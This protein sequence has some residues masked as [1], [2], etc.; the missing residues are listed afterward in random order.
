MNFLNFLLNLIKHLRNLPVTPLSFLME[1]TF[2]MNL[3]LIEGA[4]RNGS[5]GGFGFGFGFGFLT[6]RDDDDVT[7]EDDDEVNVDESSRWKGPLH[8]RGR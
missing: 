1:N 8:S 4:E 5:A 6:G 7:G 2:L 3:N